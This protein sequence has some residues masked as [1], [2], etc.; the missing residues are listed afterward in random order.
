MKLAWEEAPQQ[1]AN[2][3]VAEREETLIN[4]KGF[5]IL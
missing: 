5:I 3:F 4:G 1:K 2:L